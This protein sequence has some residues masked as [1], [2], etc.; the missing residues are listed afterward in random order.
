VA[1][2]IIRSL[3][4]TAVAAVLITCIA[5]L[6]KSVIHHWLEKDIESFKTRILGERDAADTPATGAGDASP[7]VANAQPSAVGHA[8]QRSTGSGVAACPGKDQPVAGVI[9]VIFTPDSGLS[10]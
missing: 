10:I 2:L 4:Q 1:D 7:V 3:E 6:A 9:R 5:F 8:C